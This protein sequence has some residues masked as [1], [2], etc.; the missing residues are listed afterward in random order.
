MQRI[1]ERRDIWKVA[2]QA[3]V[4][5]LPGSVL[6]DRQY[7]VD[8]LGASLSTGEW[9]IPVYRYSIIKIKTIDNCIDSRTF[10]LPLQLRCSNCYSRY[11]CYSAITVILLLLLLPCYYPAITAITL[12]RSLEQHHAGR[13]QKTQVQLPRLARDGREPGP[14]V[15]Q[16]QPAPG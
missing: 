8:L 11:Y 3:R 12:P 1:V 6:E 14:G 5:S 4:L 16:L 13:C 2:E 7:Q 9:D 10:A 15:E